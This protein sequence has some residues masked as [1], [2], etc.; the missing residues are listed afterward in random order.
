MPVRVVQGDITTLEVDAIVNAANQE[1]AG[2]GGVDGAI[3]RAGGPEIMVET[4]KRFPG[5]CR[6]GAAVTTRAGALKARYVIHAVGPRWRG[7]A[8]GEVQLL[9]S[10][11]RSALHEAIAH[12]CRTVAVPS[13]STGIYGFP[14]QGAAEIAVR[15]ILSVLGDLPPGRALDVLICAFS[16]EDAGVYRKALASAVTA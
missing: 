2:G 4:L 16:A 8:H 9:A 6:T 14:I 12:E 3:H 15:E 11:W 13:L 7:G 5:G 1:L 10:A